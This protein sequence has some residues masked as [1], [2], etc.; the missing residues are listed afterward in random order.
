MGIQR[1]KRK[2]YTKYDETDNLKRMK[3]SDIL[4]L[5]PKKLSPET[6]AGR[7]GIN[8]AMEGAVL[9]GITGGAIGA[10][11]EGIGKKSMDAAWKG[12]QSGGKR[13]LIIGAATLGLLK[14]LSA[15]KRGENEEIDNRF[16]NN[17]L[18]YA[19]K[20][21]RRREQAD[22]IANINNRDGY[23]F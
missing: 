9:G 2:L 12:A 15:Q 5:E 22:W 10:L 11:S 7:R 17:R 4:A 16:Y 3:D 23:S 21:A 14:A 20:M 18:K 6:S 1:F 13:G 19:Q 8:G